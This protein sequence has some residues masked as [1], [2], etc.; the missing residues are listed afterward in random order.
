MKILVTGG[1]GFIGSHLCESLLNDGHFVYCV[2][3]LSTGYRK[4]INH[5]ETNSKFQ[6]I[7]HDV[8]DPLNLL[9]D[10]IYSLASPASP[11]QYQKNP[12]YTIKTNVLGSINMLELAL[13]NKARILL[14][15]TSEIYGNPLEHPQKETYNGNINPCSERACYNESKRCA[16]TLFYN[17]HKN[18]NIDIR[19]IRIFNCYGPKLA[20]GDGRVISN[21]IEQALKNEPITIYGNGL[22]TRSFQYID[23]LII[24]MKKMMNSDLIGPVNMGNPI[25]FTI[26]ELANLIRILTGSSSEIVYKDLP[27]DDP[28]RRKPDISLAKEK[29]G[30]EPKISLDLGLLKTIEY[31][32]LTN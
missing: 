21:F 26:K 5:L 28:V 16:E 10:Q 6:F 18:Y 20:S 15:S 25:E 2:D 14:S 3:N 13:K 23:D 22:Q 30:W 8:I 19:I 1:A 9:V 12:V 31:F 29:L 7:Y 11:I 4:N 27:N 24:G 32:R 17:Y